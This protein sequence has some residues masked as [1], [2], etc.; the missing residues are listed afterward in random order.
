MPLFLTCL[1]CLSEKMGGLKNNW[2]FET[3]VVFLFGWA[4]W[5]AEVRKPKKAFMMSHRL[6]V[7]RGSMSFQWWRS[8]AFGFSRGCPPINS[9]LCLLLHFS[10][11]VFSESTASSSFCAL[12]CFP[13]WS[14]RIFLSVI[15]AFIVGDE[16][17]DFNPFL[18]DLHLVCAL[19]LCFPCCVLFSLVCFWFAWATCLR[20]CVGM[21]VFFGF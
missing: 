9:I 8:C 1:F 5:Q 13:E 21:L 7:F 15:F 2:F 18:P 17:T 10:Y 19:F 14:P 12:I 6:W 20:L 16:T 11:Y 3:E 4:T